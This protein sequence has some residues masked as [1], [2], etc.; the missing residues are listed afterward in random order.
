MTSFRCPPDREPTLAQ[1]CKSLDEQKKNSFHFVSLKPNLLSLLV[2]HFKVCL[3][4]GASHDAHYV[5]IDQIFKSAVFLYN[6]STSKDADNP[7][8]DASQ[9][10]KIFV[11]RVEFQ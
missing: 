9:S 8:T 11:T 7:R 2:L 3:C 10:N 1:S 6:T 4:G 5:A